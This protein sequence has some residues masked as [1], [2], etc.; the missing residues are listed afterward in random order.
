MFAACNRFNLIV[1]IFALHVIHILLSKGHNQI[2]MESVKGSFS[3][4]GDRRSIQ[5]LVCPPKGFIFDII[6][7]PPLNHS[8]KGRF[9]CL[10][11]GIIS[12]EGGRKIPYTV[13]NGFLNG[14]VTRE[15]E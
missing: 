5:Y 8:I 1:I 13:V 11:Q 10:A 7:I 9:S 14:C 15:A 6:H 12:T 2:W 4:I 3:V